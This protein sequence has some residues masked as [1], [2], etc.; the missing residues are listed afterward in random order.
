MA[1][2]WR[3]ANALAEPIDEAQ[4]Q[5]VGPGTHDR[6]QR[7]DRAGN[8]VAREHD[9]LWR[10]CPVGKAAGGDLEDAIGGLRDTFDDAE[11][12]RASAQHARQEHR[13]QRVDH[14]GRHVVT[15]ITREQPDR[16][17]QAE[18]GGGQSDGG[19]Q[20]NR[21]RDVSKPFD[22]VLMIAFGGPQAQPD[23]RPFLENVLRGRRVAPDASRKWRTTTS[24]AAARPSRS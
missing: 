23:V 18:C 12:H 22:A 5:H 13:E 6:D 20:Y 16:T 3:A 7:P 9:P 2:R 1:S 24:W 14:L 17:R 15:D 4:S 21:R 8:P 10:T 11:R 19:N